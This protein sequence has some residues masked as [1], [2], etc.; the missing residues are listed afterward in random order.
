VH[1]IQGADLTRLRSVG[2]TGSPLSPEG[3]RWVYDE[4]GPDTWLFST[5]GG[6]DVCTAFVGGV[7][8][9]PVHEGE[10]QAR[11][12]GADVQSFDEDGQA[13]TGAVG[14]LVITQ[15]LPSMPLSFWNDP[16]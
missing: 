2:V 12:L 3:F 1:P 4:L 5:S 15:P 6:T 9:L 14:E 7:P 11:S 8:L 13:L 16:D 10:L